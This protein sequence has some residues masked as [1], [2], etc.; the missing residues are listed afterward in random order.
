MEQ[1]IQ[2]Y[3]DMR[4]RLKA[5]EYFD[6]LAGWDR[7]TEAPKGSQA[8]YSKMVEVM[9]LERYALESQADYMNAIETLFEHLDTLDPDLRVEIKNANKALR[10]IKCVPKDELIAYQV[11]VSGASNVWAQAKDN[12]DFAAFEKTLEQVV[13]F[14][15]KLVKYLETDTLKGY[16]V[17]LDL[18]EEGMGVKDYD[19]FFDHLRTELVPFVKEVMD[20]PKKTY[21]RRLKSA[22]Y[23]KDLQQSF[24]MYLLDVFKYDQSHGVLKTSAHPFTSGV[25]SVDTRITTHY[26]ETNITSSIFSTIHEMGHAIYEMQ[27]DPK[28]DETNLHGGSSLGI[29]ESQSRL[30]ENMIGRSR[31]FWDTHYGALVNTFPKQLKNISLDDFFGYINQAKRSLIR[32]EADELTYALH[33]MV[34][35]ELEKAMINGRLKVSDLPKK[36][37]LLMGR[38]VGKRPANDKEGVLQDIHWSF[39]SIGYFPTYA[40][41][42]AYAAQ[43]YDAMAKELDIDQ[44]IRTNQISVINDW[45]K[46]HVHRFGQSKTPKEIIMHATGKPFDPSHYVTYL[47][48]KFRP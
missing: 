21:P 18:Y 39:G 24:S 12:D 1:A 41:G 5:Y 6:W 28:Y 19:A 13:A 36:W 34:R 16:D 42:S 22:R 4:K 26:D 25:A 46:D 17:L 31:A 29:H 30:Y 38:Y 10:M 14:N 7:E 15:R 37:R 32:I 48:D 9:A 44:L 47:K 2:T 23:P 40:L 20:A 11:L 33:V 43:I 45:L 27:N 35:Y 8:Y 3:L